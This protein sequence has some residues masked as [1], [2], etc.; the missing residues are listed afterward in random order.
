MTR[1]HFEIVT[2][3]PIVD[4]LLDTRNPRIRDGSDQADCI[5]RILRK[6]DQ[7][8][9]LMKDIAENG[10]TTMPILAKPYGDKWVVVDG[11]RRITALKLLNDAELCPLENLKHQIKNI[12][13]THT[14][15][16]FNKV[17]L[18]TS[19]NDEVIAKE[20]L[21]RH[22]GAQGGA[23]Q[24]NWNA[25]M[26][27]VF[28][29]NNNHPIDYK[30]PGQYALW[31]EKNGISVDD[32]FPI[33]SLQRFFTSENLEKLGFSIVDDELNPIL[34]L[35][36][37]KRMAQIVLSDFGST[38][39]VDDVRTG[40][41]ANEY[42]QTVR[43]RVGLVETEPAKKDPTE[44]DSSSGNGSNDFSRNNSSGKSDENPDV[45]EPTEPPKDD[46][47][48]DGEETPAKRVNT[49]A[50]PSW[51][52][53]KVFG[54]KAPG[55][56]IPGSE[57]KATNILSELRKIDVKESPI[58]AC[59]LMRGL[60]ELSDKYYREKNKLED[61]SKL[62]KN[63]VRSATHMRDSQQ[64]TKSEFDSVKRF[65]DP[66]TQDDLLHV[67][68]LQKIMHRETHH[69]NFQIVNSFWDNISPFVKACWQS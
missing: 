63:I 53:K 2:D 41:K 47:S 14:D 37:V 38:I 28:Q 57:A 40:S 10:L 52:R 3:V 42:I 29:I 48:G 39:N 30:R 21:S 31:A 36:I 8:I 18:L 54:K 44:A 26:R 51:D 35:H 50:T 46:I 60:I 16:I 69:P 25:Y 11:N 19:S 5:S 23:G 13:S 6:E 68:T 64:L 9:T 55:I 58:A 65:A 22:S 59:M 66:N 1:K 67:E 62:G 43:S 32:D 12:A 34:P 45:T 20:I 27:T 49:P 4:V 33:T 17:D 7:L 61:L 24:L 15:N 56:G